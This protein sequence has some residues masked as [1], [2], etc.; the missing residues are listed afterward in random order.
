[1]A[2]TNKPY[3]AC[4]IEKS[5]NTIALC[6][7]IFF[8]GSRGYMMDGWDEWMDQDHNIDLA[9]QPFTDISNIMLP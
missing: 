6:E 1:M 3:F 8:P 4:N 7:L 9:T 2:W 5:L